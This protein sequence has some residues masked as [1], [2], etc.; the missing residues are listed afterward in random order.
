MNNDKYQQLLTKQN[1]A[2]TL[3]ITVLIMIAMTIGSIGMLSS[4]RMETNMT[5]NDQNNREALQAAQA[6]ID[7]YMAHMASTLVYDDDFVDTLCDPDNWNTQL[8]P[9]AAQLEFLFNFNGPSNGLLD[10]DQSTQAE[11]CRSTP[12][13]IITTSEIWV[14]G[15]SRDGTSTRVLSSQID[16]ST[17]WNHSTPS[18]RGTPGGGNEPLAMCNGDLQMP[19]DASDIGFCSGSGCTA[20]PT[21]GNQQ[22]NENVSYDGTLVNLSSTATFSQGS[23]R[24]QGKISQSDDPI[25][26]E[27]CFDQFVG[28]NISREEF[29]S[30]ATKI[31][32]TQG[33]GGTSSIPAGQTQFFVDGDLRLNAGSVIGTPTNP[34]ILMVRGDARVNGHATV[35]GTIYFLANEDG[36]TPQRT[37][38]GTFN[39][40]G[41][42]VS[43]TDL[44][45]SG[46]AA[47]YSDTES[48]ATPIDYDPSTSLDLESLQ[49]S[50]NV[51]IG[52]WREVFNSLALGQ[53]NNDEQDDD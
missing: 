43:E 27:Q 11:L 17:A 22:G 52:S 46:N 10:F 5:I 12:H 47:I 53:E 45:I 51:R 6:G 21:T 34:V 39:V 24:F 13:A 30:L 44:N 32:P 42:V 36:S 28:E 14:R 37:M 49:R 7:F 9:S 35:W 20:I 1:G 40:R 38:N 19:S 50:A 25:T 31:T 2:V 3:L 48:Q 8:D 18:T 26:N 41:R 15:F 29:M 4:T 33:Q 23:S 16:L